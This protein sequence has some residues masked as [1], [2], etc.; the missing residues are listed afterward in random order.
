M[1]PLK[2]EKIKT[3]GNHELMIKWGDKKLQLIEAFRIQERCPC[4]ECDGVF[5]KVDPRV[6]I[7]R[8]EMKGRLGLKIQFSS[9][10]SR[11]IYTF[12]EI[13]SWLSES[14]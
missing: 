4:I 13:R 7:D 1:N 2:I 5:P 10:C 9:G 12:S 14:F 6:Q 3:A 11:G 8:F